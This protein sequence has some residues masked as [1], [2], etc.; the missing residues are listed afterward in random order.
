M[1][2]ELPTQSDIRKLVAATRPFVEE[3]RPR[4]WAY[5]ISTFV[6]LGGAF[7]LAALAPWP[8]RLI[9][10]VLA[11]LVMI[12]GFVLYHD[13]M[14]GALLRRSK[15]ARALFSVYGLLVLAPPRAWRANHNFH[16][17][18]VGQIESSAVGN[19][20]LMTTDMWAEAPTRTRIYY[21]LAR[22]PLVILL[23]YP[24]VF[25]VSL[26]I[27]PLLRDPKRH[28]D[29]VASLVLHAGVITGLWLWQGAAAALLIVMIPMAVSTMVGAYFFYAQHSY[30]GM[31]ILPKDEW[32]VPKAAIASCSYLKL[33]PVMK[34]I[35]GDI[36]Y[37]H[38]H[39]LN[40]AIPFYRLADAKRA[41][42]A[43]R[44]PIITTLWPRDILRCLRLKL[45]DEER[46]ELV[47]FPRR[48]RQPAHSG[49]TPA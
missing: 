46:R 32:S 36:G 31:D 42:P 44:E 17:A 15:L 33:G 10:T 12:R 24:L 40:A 35:S 1:L 48:G 8:W 4:S 21:R 5:V 20:W 11:S 28:W 29:S 22:S 30:V 25:G 9:G 27:M 13:H 37:H 16:H 26:T 43:L 19:F 39:H 38:V 7:T 47:G 3:S 41:L 34:W 18:H 14:H 6:I 45:W 49:P 2:E 23:A